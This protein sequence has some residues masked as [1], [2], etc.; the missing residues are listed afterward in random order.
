MDDALA[1]H[2]SA[3]HTEARGSWTMAQHVQAFLAQVH[4]EWTKHAGSAGWSEYIVER[5]HLLFGKICEYKAELGI[6]LPLHVVEDRVLDVWAQAQALLEGRLQ[7]ATAIAE[8][9]VLK[10]TAFR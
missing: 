3:G 10:G 4:K 8:G 7:P 5:F 6:W 9:D 2:R 1:A